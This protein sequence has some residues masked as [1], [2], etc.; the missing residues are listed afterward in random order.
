MKSCSR[1]LLFVILFGF[2]ISEAQNLTPLN[3]YQNTGEINHGRMDITDSLLFWP[4]GE[5]GM[6]IFDVSNPL[7]IERVNLFKEYELRSYRKVYGSVNSVQ[8]DGNTAY[9]AHG[10]LG[11]KIIDFSDPVKPVTKGVYYRHIPVNE[12]LLY[13]D[14]AFL[15]LWGNG[16][17][18]V[19]YS[20]WKD[21]SLVSRKNMG[22]IYVNKLDLHNRYLYA[23]CGKDGIRIIPYKKPITDFKSDG[24][25]RTYFP[26]GEVKDL[27]IDEDYAFVAN[28]KK[29][30]LV[31]NLDLPEH[32]TTHVKIETEGR[33]NGLF[34]QENNL[35]VATTR[36]IEIFSV[37]DKENIFKI[38]DF[39]DNKR[40]YQTLLVEDNYLYGTYQRN[41]LFSKHYGFG[42][43]QIQ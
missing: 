3:F 7:N 20:D 31:L 13:K 19:D 32:P 40:S 1:L 5:K 23:A 10:D 17:E 30:L 41:S 26:E 4:L 43:F 27:I 25:I 21:I 15:G 2:Q 11:F 28:G 24:F 37:E 39:S 8:L 6:L 42:I 35:F 34:L 12:F 29:S 9:I 18:A 22:G 16:V 14:Y 33:C 38:N 36:G